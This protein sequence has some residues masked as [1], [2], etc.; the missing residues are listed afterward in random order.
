MLIDKYKISRSSLVLALGFIITAICLVIFG[1][2]AEDVLDN[3]ILSFDTFVI[4]WFHSFQNL[5]SIMFWITQ[6]GSVESISVFS[7]LTIYYLQR[8]KKGL[9]DISFFILTVGGGALLNYVLKLSFHRSRPSINDFIDAVGFSFPSGHAMGS[10]IFY[11][12][13]SYFILRSQR[14]KRMKFIF[15]LLSI[16]FILMIG[17]SRIYL[18]AHYPS[19]V[20]AGYLAGFS[21]LSFCIFSRNLYE[22]RIS[23]D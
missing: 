19:D 18:N 9:I 20:I 11:G 4:N 15:T 7:L 1:A 14:N 16:A 10:M 12:A 21:W 5:D 22:K 3:E 8:Y 17:I 13:V 23:K 6:S 2:I